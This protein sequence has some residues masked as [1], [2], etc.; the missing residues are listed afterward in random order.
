MYFYREASFYKTYMYYY[1]VFLQMNIVVKII[2][3]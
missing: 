3:Y 2:I 1:Y